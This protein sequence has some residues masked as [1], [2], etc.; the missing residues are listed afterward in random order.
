MI[1]KTYILDIDGTLLEHI[2]DFKDICSHPSLRPLPGAREK[3]S[4]WHC[5]GHVIVLITARPEGL[6]KLTELQLHNAGIIYDMLIMGVGQGP[7][8]LV[9]DFVPGSEQK[10]IAVNIVRNIDGIINVNS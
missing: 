6:R 7:R 1:S 9:N 8:I 5:E 4:K 2:P 3:T 10:A